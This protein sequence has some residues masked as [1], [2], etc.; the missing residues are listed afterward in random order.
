M[1]H[2]GVE[3]QREGHQ[4]VMAKAMPGGDSIWEVFTKKTEE[5]EGHH[6]NIASQ[7]QGE[8]GQR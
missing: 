2:L 6:E 1:G 7:G 8:N 3:V 5:E 4:Y